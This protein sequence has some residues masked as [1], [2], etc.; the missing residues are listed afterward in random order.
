MTSRRAMLVLVVCNLL[1]A[2]T[3]VAGKIAL[4]TLSPVELNALRFGIAGLIFLPFLWRARGRVILDRTALL[5]LA[6]LC[7]LGFVVNKALEFGGLDLT[8]ASDTAL[9]IAAEGVFTAIFGWML[10]REAVRGWAVCGLLLAVLGVYLV[11]ERGLVL[12]HLGAGTR[13]V[14]DLLILAALV[15]E[16]LYS[17]LG[18]S[19]LSRLPAIAVTAGGIVGS[20]AVWLPAAGVNLA[21]QGPPQPT[22]ATWGAVLYLAIAGTVLAYLGWISALGHVRASTAAPTLFLQPLVGSMLAAL[23][24]GERLGWAS[25]AGGVLIVGGIWM[26]SRDEAEAESVVVA[27]ETLA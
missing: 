9:L 21:A 2:G 3:Y 18:K 24:L 27:T 15:S 16:A 22:P 11:V 14:G 1:W 17:V 13:V 10:L 25:V 8:T 4:R 23:I 26:V 19:T 7:L 20:L 6:L 5:R 12:P